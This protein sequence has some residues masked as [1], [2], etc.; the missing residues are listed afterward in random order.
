M[1]PVVQHV[2]DVAVVV[3]VVVADVRV[4]LAVV[5]DNVILH[6]QVMT[7]VQD[8]V[9]VVVV[10]AMDAL[11]GVDQDVVVGVEVDVL[12]P[13]LQVAHTDVK[14]VVLVGVR[15]DVQ[16]VLVVAGVDVEL[17]AL[18]ALDVMIVVEVVVELVIQ[19]VAVH[20]QD[21]LVATDVLKHVL[22]LLMEIVEVDVLKDVEDAHLDV[23][24]DVVEVAKVD[25][26]DFVHLVQEHAKIVRDVLAVVVQRAIAQVVVNAPV[27]LEVVLL[28]VVAIVK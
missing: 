8:V 6:V 4:V 11:Q 18:V 5:V 24:K 15:A 13:V 22:T 1:E 7:A 12:E 14:V 2:Q 9:L 25:V 16:V 27:V 19:T 23:R 28:D 3:L 17:R 21:A 10:D 20:V 26:V